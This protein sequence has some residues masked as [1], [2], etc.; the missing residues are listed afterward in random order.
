MNRPFKKNESGKH[1]HAVEDL[2]EWVN[3]KIEVPFYIDSEIA[4]VPDIVCT[5]NGIITAMYEVV[6][7]H[8]VSGHKLA[9]IQMWS[10]FNHTEFSLFEVS[11]EWILKQTEKPER[12]IQIDSYNIN[13]F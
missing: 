13:P 4:F 1:R 9:M 8:P 10:Y 6:N 3:G 2:A 11:A 7:T 12:I 5:D